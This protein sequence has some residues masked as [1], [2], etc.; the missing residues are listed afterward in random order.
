MLKINFHGGKKQFFP[1]WHAQTSVRATR[2]QVTLLFDW[3]AF[4]VKF[5]WSLSLVC[6]PWVYTLP[7]FNPQALAHI[8]FFH[9]KTLWL[10]CS[11]LSE[12]FSLLWLLDCHSIGRCGYYLFQCAI[13]CGFYLIATTIWERRLLSSGRKMKKSTGC[14]CQGGNPKRHCHAHLPLQ[15]IPNLRNKIP[16]QISWRRANSFWKTA[17][18]LYHAFYNP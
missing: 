13:L 8:S 1:L 12:S 7:L 5:V 6:P 18:P 16:S 15:R 3:L 2:A 10:L 4:A 14:R 17:D 9:L 11:L